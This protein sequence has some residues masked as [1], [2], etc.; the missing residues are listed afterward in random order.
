MNV[1]VCVC[2]CVCVSVCVCVLD[3]LLI[4]IRNSFAFTSCYQCTILYYHRI[5]SCV[6]FKPISYDVIIIN[7]IELYH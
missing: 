4:I 7:I 2:V 6:P 3:P 5:F 1:F